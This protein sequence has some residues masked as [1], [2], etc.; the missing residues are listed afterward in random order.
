MIP[1]PKMS[2]SQSVRMSLLPFIEIV[3]VVPMAFLSHHS[4]LLSYV[5][6]V[7]V[8]NPHFLYAPLCGPTMILKF[9][10]RSPSVK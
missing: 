3:T 9:R 1:F 7:L 6:M 4:S 8:L 5:F 2:T 10:K